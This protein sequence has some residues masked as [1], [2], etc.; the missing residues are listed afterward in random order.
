MDGAGAEFGVDGVKGAVEGA[1]FFGLGLV[2][3]LKLGV[4]LSQVFS[5]DADEADGR[6]GFGGP[7][8]EEGVGG[9][10]EMV[11]AV[12][13]G[14]EGFGAGDG[15]EVSEA[16]FEVDAAGEE[17]VFA[18]AGG[19]V[20]GLFD[21]DVAEVFRVADVCVEG[22]FVADG[23][24]FGVGSD[25]AG[26]DAVGEVGVVVS[27]RA[28][29]GGH[30]FGGHSAEVGDGFDADVVEGGF[31]FFADAP[32]A[33]DGERGED[34]FD[35][36]GVDDEEAVGFV[37]VGGEFGEEFIGGDA[38]GGGECGFVADG[39]FD[40]A[41]DGFWGTAELEGAGDVEVGFVD[42]DGFDDGGEAFEDGVDLLGELAVAREAA[43]DD[44]G[45]GT[46]A[47]GDDDGLGGVAAKFAGFVAGGG[48]DAARAV[49][50]DED[51]LAAEGGVVELFDGGEEGVHVD[52]EDVAGGGHE[53][54]IAGD[55]NTNRRKHEVTP[56]PA[57]RRNTK[58]I[59]GEWTKG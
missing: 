40:V 35:V 10:E 26:V 6:E 23:F 32:E 48:D 52:V 38:D 9:F 17:V 15:L 5:G 34:G 30:P 16:D 47:F 4:R 37:H 2:E 58:R 59:F 42:G 14:G 28:E 55:V 3:E 20:F 54:I 13:G 46:E 43:G 12:G 36:F 29:V 57:I 7:N 45:L 56:P 53:G 50:A 31:G 11:G 21:E 44:D 19:D 41:G 24:G 1:G 39:L 22:L 8:V 49:V 51:G 27:G 25:F 33:S 18:E